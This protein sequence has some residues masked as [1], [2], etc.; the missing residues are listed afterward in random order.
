MTAAK[1]ERCCAWTDQAAGMMVPPRNQW[2]WYKQAQQRCAHSSN[3]C[4][5]SSSTHLLIHRHKGVIGGLTAAGSGQRI[6]SLGHIRRHCSS[7]ASGLLSNK[8]DCRSK[9]GHRVQSA[10][11]AAGRAV[12]AVSLLLAAD[13]SR[14]HGCLCHA[15]VAR[16]ASVSTDGAS[17]NRRQAVLCCDVLSMRP[18]ASG[19]LQP[20]LLSS[21]RVCS[22]GS[23]QPP[24]PA[25]ST[26]A[27]QAGRWQTPGVSTDGPGGADT[28]HWAFK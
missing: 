8:V 17:S 4:G 6:D 23:R 14:W 26:T 22:P 5:T 3:T 27:A 9:H 1:Q 7:L 16:L 15:V 19:S 13:S 10:D 11:M 28:I 12:L 20:H 25:A 18:L 2:L 24:A 21:W